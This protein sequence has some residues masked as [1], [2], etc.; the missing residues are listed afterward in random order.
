MDAF[1]QHLN[2]TADRYTCLKKDQSVFKAQLELFNK[3]KD[4]AVRT[5]SLEI[6]MKNLKLQV[7]LKKKLSFFVWP[8]ITS[9]KDKDI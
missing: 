6:E 1:N 7:G 2:F 3:D 4:L 5:K 9:S 8:L